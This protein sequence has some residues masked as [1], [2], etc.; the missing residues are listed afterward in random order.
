MGYAEMLSESF[1]QVNLG[2]RGM[3]CAQRESIRVREEAG[4]I[5]AKQARLERRDLRRTCEHPASDGKECPD[6]GHLFIH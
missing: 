2:H 4:E 5:T 3:I 6:C 1:T